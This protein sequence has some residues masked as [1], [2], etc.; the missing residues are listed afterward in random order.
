VPQGTVL[1]PLL[2]LV[3]INDLPD[4]VRSQVRLFADDCLLYRTIKSYKDHVTLQ[5]DLV[6]LEWVNNWGMEF[7]KKK[8]FI[9]SVR[10]KT[11]YYYQLNCTILKGVNNIP[12]LVSSTYMNRYRT[13][14]Q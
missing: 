7:N 13:C 12:V 8:C 2:F 14:L 9:L 4:A 10:A 11:D 5:Q 3:D 1:W 6:K